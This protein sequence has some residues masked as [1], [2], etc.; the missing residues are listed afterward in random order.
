M[1]NFRPSDHPDDGNLSIRPKIFTIFDHSRLEQGARW[2]SISDVSLTNIYILDQPLLRQIAGCIFEYIFNGS[3]RSLG[4]PEN[5]KLVEY[6]VAR[7]VRNRNIKADEPLALLAATHYFNTQTEWGWDHFLVDALST[8]NESARGIA[9][10]QVGA[11]LLGLAFSSPTPLSQ[12]FDFVDDN[13]LKDVKAQLVAIHKGHE[14]FVSTPANILSAELIGNYVLGYSPRTVKDTLAWLEDPQQTLFC[15]AANKVGPDL[16]FVLRLPDESLL[17]VVI[18]FKT[19]EDM[20]PD[21]TENALRTTDPTQFTAERRRHTEDAER[22]PKTRKGRG[23]RYILLLGH[24]LCIS[25]F[26]TAQKNLTL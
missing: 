8:S 3:P 5:K 11:Y 15:F 10:E 12:V 20:G 26:E 17:R 21:K 9:F 4:G 6:G 14:G 22:R 23:K 25:P 18:Q 19:E 1:T 24:S 2:I 13:D 7:F 16:I